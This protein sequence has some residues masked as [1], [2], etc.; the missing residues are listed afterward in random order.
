ME[1]AEAGRVELSAPAEQEMV[2][3]G[4]VRA[5]AHAAWASC[6]PAGEAGAQL[7]SLQWAQAAPELSA[8]AAQQDESRRA[9]LG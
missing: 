8:A 7:P 6:E 4:S 2:S 3:L 9:S 1:Q 5:R